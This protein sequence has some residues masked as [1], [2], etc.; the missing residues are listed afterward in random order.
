MAKQFRLVFHAPLGGTLAMTDTHIRRLDMSDLPRW[1]ALAHA[2]DW[3]WEEAQ[4]AW[5]AASGAV[6]GLWQQ[7][8]LLATVGLYGE[9]P[10]LRWLGVLIVHPSWQRRGLGERMVHHALTFAP[11]AVGL[12]AT[13]QGQPLYEKL[14]FVEVG[15]VVRMQYLATHGE[16][17]P[18]LP[19]AWAGEALVLHTPADA[20]VR[21]LS[22]PDPALVRYDEAVT[23]LRREGMYRALLG[24]DLPGRRWGVIATDRNG[25]VLGLGWAFRRTDTIVIGPVLAENE[26]TAAQLIWALSTSSAAMGALRWTMDVPSEQAAFLTRLTEHGWLTTQTSAVMLRDAEHLPGDRAL[27]FALAA[28]ALG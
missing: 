25:D 20:E 1:I 5:Y 18:P 19:T 13:R 3:Y 10:S 24:T 14:G 22:A 11:G 23:G 27:L 12:V 2:V 28:P 26:E 8:A 21:P 6:W 16:A 17:A 4:T 9:G 15:T 7:D